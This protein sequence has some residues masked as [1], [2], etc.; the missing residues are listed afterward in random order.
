MRRKLKGK[1]IGLSMT[2]DGPLNPTW[3]EWLM[4]FPMGWTE[5]KR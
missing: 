4:G 5:T 3:V 2:V 1:Q